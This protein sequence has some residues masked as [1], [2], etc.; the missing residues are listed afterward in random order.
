M[1][2]ICAAVAIK[3]SRVMPE[4][5]GSGLVSS[6]PSSCS[7]SSLSAE[8]SGNNGVAKTPIPRRDLSQSA[9]GNRGM[10]GFIQG[11]GASQN[12]VQKAHRLSAGKKAGVDL[13]G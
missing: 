9:A 1:K 7:I 11:G 6:M 13:V 5:F 8:R 4:D 12:G 10:E 2:R 3:I